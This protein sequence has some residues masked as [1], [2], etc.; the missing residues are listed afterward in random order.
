MYSM[1]RHVRE[2]PRPRTLVVGERQSTPWTGCQ[3]ITEL[4]HIIWQPFTLTFT[5]VGDSNSPDENVFGYH[6]EQAGLQSGP[7]CC[8]AKMLS[9]EPLCC[10]IPIK[11]KWKYISISFFIVNSVLLVSSVPNRF[12]SKLI[13]SM[14]H[15]L[16]SV[17]GGTVIFFRSPS[18]FQVLA[19]KSQVK[20]QHLNF[21]FQS[22][23]CIIA[24]LRLVCT[25]NMP[26]SQHDWL[27]LVDLKCT[28]LFRGR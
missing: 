12:V 25:A 24:G 23:K 6:E 2:R 14:F 7:P 18:E 8:K 28:V 13:I 16:L 20:T 5:S 27:V 22:N 19:L 15:P 17:E 9:N 4:T 1:W 10:H 21:M 11:S 26:F 3:S